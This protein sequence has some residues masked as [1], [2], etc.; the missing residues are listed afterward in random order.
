[1]AEEFVRCNG[2][3]E[4]IKIPRRGE[5]NLV[6]VLIIAHYHTVTT[7]P[8]CRFTVLRMFFGKIRWK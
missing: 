8:H 1:M 7:F 2:L 4:L 5:I 3:L 6:G